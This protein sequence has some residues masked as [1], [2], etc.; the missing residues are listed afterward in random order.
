VA[1]YDVLVVGGGFGGAFAARTLERALS[2]RRERVLLVAPENFLLF[3]PLLPEAASGTL[4]PRHAVVPL[5]EMLRRTDVVIGE[6]ADIDLDSATAH[7]HDRN[8]HE[9]T[10][11]FRALVL[12]PGSI[13]RTLPI[14]GLAEH[15]VGF[16]SLRDAIWLRNNVLAQLEAAHDTT[17]TELQRELLTFTFVGGGYAGVEAIAEL[18]S[19]A[20][21][22]LRLYPRLRR[23]LLR[24]VL[25]EAQGSLLPGLDPRLASYTEKHLR[26]RGIEVHTS[27]RLASCTDSVVVLDGEAV[28]P[29]RSRTIVWT[30]GQRPAPCVADLGV[31]LDD[32]GRVIV[33]E[34]VA[35]PGRPGVFAIGDAAAVPDPEGGIC[36]PTA[37]HAVRQGRTAGKNAAAALG[38]GAPVRFRYRNRGLA[39]TLGRW[40]GTAQVRGLRFTGPLAWWMG[41]SYHL[42][43]LPGTARRARVVSDWTVSLLFRRDVAQLGSLGTPTH[44]P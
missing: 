26:A 38:I 36:P 24:W 5:R 7:Y 18:E 39:V 44:L 43:M 2:G 4:E 17:D 3:S 25:V 29:Y 14:P 12:A 1:E 10:V 37:Q 8:G 28:A 9:H 34:H 22:A 33:D 42:L 19:L 41:R 31:A 16:K 35:V 20:H 23:D 11:E 6:I 27:T 21:D 13:P 40:D 15:A 30:T 32:G